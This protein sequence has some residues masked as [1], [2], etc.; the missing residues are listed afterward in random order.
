[1]LSSEPQAKRRPPRR[2]QAPLRPFRHR[3]LPAPAVNPDGFLNNGIHLV[4][5]EKGRGKQIEAAIDYIGDED[6]ATAVERLQKL[7]EIDE[8]VFVR[9]KR[10]NAEGSDVFVW[11]SA[12]QESDR[13]IGTLPAAGLDFYKSKFGAKAAD[14]LKKAKNNGDPGL[15]NDI[16]KKYAHTDAGAEAIKLLGDYKFDR[17]EY[18]PA[19]LCYSKLINRL[20]EEKTPPTLL[21]KAAWAAHL[22]PPSSTG[23]NTVTSTN[24][25]GE[26]E[27]WKMLR[28]RTR[29]VQF[30]EQ[31]IPVEELE[32][33]V[34]KLDRTRFEQNAA[35]SLLYRAT[36][37]R[38]NQLIGGPAFMVR[39]WHTSMLYDKDSSEAAH[40]RIEA[41][42]RAL[43]TKNQPIIAAFA[44]I[45][46]TIR[47]GEEKIPLLIYKN[48]FGVMAVDLRN[49]GLAWAS[50]SNWS[51][52]RM[53]NSPGAKQSAAAQWLDYYINQNQHP[54]ILFENSTVGTLSTDG[55]FVYSVEDLAI[56]PLPQANFN[57][58]MVFPGGMNNNVTL[59]KDIEDAISHNRLLAF[60]LATQRRAELGLGRRR[61]R[62]AARLL[63]PGTAAAVGRQTLLVGREAAGNPPHLP[64]SRR[65]GQG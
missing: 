35:D 24:V 11:V 13:L 9:L 43:E 53:L 25:F 32:E 26:K 7:L 40:S 54:Q 4:K 22:A 36:A 63:F 58:G 14:L 30:G 18:M 41:A 17:G 57:N 21:A 16:M 34:A 20:G 2:P 51:L 52:Q 8:D 37:S 64:R 47:K 45:S 56:P 62:S 38:G 46:L 44:P 42:K 59:D 12:K 49:G 15:L 50:P 33:H 5:D 1:M 10:K 27:L 19:L 31:A 28:A 23:Q 48:Y 60:S 39:Q 55:Q 29:E 65:I 6:W 61:E 3:A